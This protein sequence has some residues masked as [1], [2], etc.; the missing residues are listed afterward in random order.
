MEALVPLVFYAIGVYILYW[1][2]R[3]AVRHGIADAD[4]RREQGARKRPRP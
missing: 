3:Y 2:I 1:T 4:E